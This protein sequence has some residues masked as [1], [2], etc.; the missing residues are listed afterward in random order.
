MNGIQATEMATRTTTAIRPTNNCSTSDGLFR[1]LDQISI[2]KIVEAELNI[3]VNV[4][5]K[6][7]NIIANI[8]PIKPKIMLN[9]LVFL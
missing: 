8:I 7:A 3:E 1:I 4:E 6:A 5:N 9:I 2:A